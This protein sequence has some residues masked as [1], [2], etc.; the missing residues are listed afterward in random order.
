MGPPKKMLIYPELLQ[1]KKK[2]QGHFELT[3][4]EPHLNVVV[5]LTP[6]EYLERDTQ[7][8]LF[9]KKKTPNQTQLSLAQSLNVSDNHI[10]TG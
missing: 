2:I 8:Y 5:N 6:T 9:K 4:V 1:E 10:C 3:V 7:C